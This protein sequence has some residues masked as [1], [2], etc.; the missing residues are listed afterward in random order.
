MARVR[1]SRT[2]RTRPCFPNWSAAFSATFIASMMGRA[3]VIQF[4][5]LAGPYGLGDW[6]PEYGRFVV[7]ELDPQ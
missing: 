1:G 3:D 5:K 6:R 4:F 2:V 7:E